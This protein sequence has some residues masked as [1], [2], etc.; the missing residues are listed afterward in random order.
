M[1]KI[2]IKLGWLIIILMSLNF[3]S[4]SQFTLQDSL[5]AYYPFNGN[6]ND[7]SGNLNHGI[8]FGAVLTTDMLGDTNTAYDFDGFNDYIDIPVID[9]SSGAEISLV[10][11]VRP[12]DITSNTFYNFIRQDVPTGGPPPDWLLAFQNNGTTLSFGLRAGGSYSE[13]D[14]SINDSDFTDGNWHHIVGTYDGT[15]KK[16]Y[17]DCIEVGSQFKS[18]NIEFGAGTN[19]IGSM[20]DKEYFNGKIDD[21]RIY[22][23]ALDSA[24]INILCNVVTG[25]KLLYANNNNVFIYPNPITNR[26]TIQVNNKN[27]NIKGLR[28]Y[29]IEGR[30]VREKGNLEGNSIRLQRGDLSSGM[31]FVEVIGEDE[32]IG[33]V[34]VIVP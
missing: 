20:I 14:I 29:N 26:T 27:V 32:V 13:L 33:R 3:N 22:N 18:G 34:K 31:Y 10:A 24:D 28:I 15:I 9:L 16:L 6:V 30:L 17:V 21:V 19:R 12:N 25:I 23:R 7:E 1:K 11:W 2:D 5:K 4:F 8:G